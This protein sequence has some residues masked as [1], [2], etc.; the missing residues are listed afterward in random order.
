MP[1]LAYARFGLCPVWPIP[2]L[3][4]TAYE[5]AK[6]YTNSQL[7]FEARHP[8]ILCGVLAALMVELKSRCTAV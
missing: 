6:G 2:G 4:Y 8:E 7:S 1:G 3:A 5:R